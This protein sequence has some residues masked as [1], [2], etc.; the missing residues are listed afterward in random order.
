[1]IAHAPSPLEQRSALERV[2]SRVHRRLIETIDP[3]GLGHIDDAEFQRQLT[4]L[5]Q[6]LCEQE[7]HGLDADDRQI[8]VRE[9]M[10]EM[11]GYGPLQPL[12]ADDAV[13]D[14]LVNGPDRVYVE[15]HGLLEPTEICFADNAHLLEFMRRLAARAGRRLD[16]SNPAVEMRLADG[17][18][19]NAAIPPVAQGGPVLSLRRF[20]TTPFDWNVLIERGTLGSEMAEFLQLAVRGRTNMLV[21]GS[22]GSGKTTLLGLLARSVPR[23]ERLVVIEQLAELQLTRP[24]TV[25]LQAAAQADDS[26]EYLVNQAVRMRPDRLIVSEVR[27]REAFALL[28]SM[29]TGLPGSMSAIQA[30]DVHDALERLELML[31]VSDAGLAVSA[32][33]KYISTAIQI[34]V[35]V[36]RLSTGERKI[37]RISELAPAR[38]TDY[39]VQDIFVYRQ[40]GLDEEGRA[41]GGFYATGYEPRCLRRMSMT[42]LS[43]ADG[44][45]EPRELA[46]KSS[47]IRTSEVRS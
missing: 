4:A 8:I 38:D 2:K 15:R 12:F 20:P 41:D 40:L 47:R 23:T 32:A 25:L 31:T 35:Q 45:F 26:L 46:V 9:L 7:A 24:E 39:D 36:S 34:V 13:T 5:A 42:G 33:R 16:Q 14:I 17:T 22:S 21:V 28:Q 1:M 6:H 18:R 11:F 27:G 43:P 37:T 29:H 30:G 10:D 3:A 44:L 19:L